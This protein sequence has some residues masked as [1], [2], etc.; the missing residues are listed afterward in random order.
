MNVTNLQRMV[1]LAVAA[2]VFST[3]CSTQARWVNC[4]RK[5]EPINVVVTPKARREP[6]RT[7]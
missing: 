3:A 5:L 4:D 1:A 7:P 2:A 6:R